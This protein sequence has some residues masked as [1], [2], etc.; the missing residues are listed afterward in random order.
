MRLKLIFILINIS[1]IMEAQNVDKTIVWKSTYVNT[2]EYTT[3]KATDNIIVNGQITGEGLGKLLNV[4]YKLEINTRWEIQSLFISVQSDT[5]FTIS[6]Q[7]DKEGQW[8]D[9]KGKIQTQLAQCTDIDISLTPFTN[10]LPINRLNLPVGTSKEIAVIY[11]DLPK[12]HYKPVKQRYT[13]MGNGIY[14]YENLESGFTSMLE[15]DKDGIVL[16]SPG[17]W[18]R[19]FPENEKKSRLKEIFSDALISSHPNEEL[20]DAAKIYDWLIGS[21]EVEA[22]D[23]LDENRTIRAQGEWHFSWVLEGR[24]IEDVW[25]APKR[26]LRE[27]NPTQP[28]N[29]Y[30]ISFRYFD[31][32][33]QKWCVNWFNPISGASDKLYGRKEG[34]KIIHEGL[35]DNGN[36]MRWSFED[37]TTNSFHWKGELSYDKGKTF[38]LQAEFLGKRK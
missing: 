11:I 25:I 22:I 26:S 29:R 27:K 36:L 6:L 8:M 34:E 7:K 31:K 16:N 12:N 21:W 9:D 38:V 10:T 3:I 33:K 17:I 1:I 2:T 35:D 15:V 30:G 24:A 5:S 19:V 28:R 37:I 14:K 20:K 13:N 23:Y 4:K 32:V 18:H